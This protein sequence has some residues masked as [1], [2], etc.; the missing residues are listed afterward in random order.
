M[1]PR[2]HPTLH[3]MSGL[4][5]VTAISMALIFPL[6]VQMMGVEFAQAQ[7]T[8][9]PTPYFYAGIAI[10][11]SIAPVPDSDVD[12]SGACV[13]HC[14][15]ARIGFYESAS[16]PVKEGRYTALHV[17]PPD[18]S[19]FNQTV[20]FHLDGNQAQET[21]TFLAGGPNFHLSFTLTF[22]LATAAPTFVPTPTPTPTGTPV[23][24]PPSPTNTPVI[25]VVPSGLSPTGPADDFRED[26]GLPGLTL[27]LFTALAIGG[28]GVTAG[29]WLLVRRGRQTARRQ[30]RETF[31]QKVEADNAKTASH[32]RLQH[33]GATGRVFGEEERKEDEGKTDYFTPEGEAVG[34]VSSDQASVLAIHTAREIPGDYGRQ[35]E[36]IPMAFEVLREVQ[37]EDHYVITLSFRPQ[38]DFGGTPGQEEFF[39]EKEG[40]VVHRQILSLPRLRGW[41]RWL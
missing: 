34:Y 5:K 4:Y 33:P 21:D 36:G 20:T 11:E 2:F 8:P 15:T 18:Q 19:F 25:I 16:V 27:L 3:Q 12:N 22:L 37:R 17:S 1:P 23:I 24:S 35:F 10:T 9:P 29:W 39:I 30:Q 14:I 31:L 26:G 40:T 32:R 41:R 6:V 38:G 7:S 28:T 13:T